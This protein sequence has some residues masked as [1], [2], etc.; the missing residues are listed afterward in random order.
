MKSLGAFL[1]FLSLFLI[2]NKNPPRWMIRADNCI[3]LVLIHSCMNNDNNGIVIGKLEI[4]N[5]DT[6]IL[7]KVLFKYFS[8]KYLVSSNYLEQ[9]ESYF[10]NKSFVIHQIFI[11]RTIFLLT[12]V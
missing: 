4:P 5:L 6:M 2:S 12:V 8:S 3:Y 1:D 11:K 10:K 7:T 9:L